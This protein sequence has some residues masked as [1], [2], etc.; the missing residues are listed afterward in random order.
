MFSTLRVWAIATDHAGHAAGLC[1]AGI[2]MWL[3][4]SGLLL[5]GVRLRNKQPNKPKS[6]AETAA[7]ITLDCG[8]WTAFPYVAGSLRTRPGNAMA[9]TWNQYCVPLVNPL[10]VHFDAGLGRPSTIGLHEELNT[11]H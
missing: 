5:G 8:L 7:P 3:I 10:A 2:A 4:G 11:E 1:L 6:A 9:P